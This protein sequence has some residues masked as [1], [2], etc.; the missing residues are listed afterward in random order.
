MRDGF[1]GNYEDCILGE[2]CF[3]GG[4]GGYPPGEGGVVKTE[5]LNPGGRL[6]PSLRGIGKGGVNSRGYFENSRSLCFLRECNFSLG[7][8]YLF[9]RKMIK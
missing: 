7:E 2:R 3:F 4:L 9:S 8:I 5:E 6:S 1:L